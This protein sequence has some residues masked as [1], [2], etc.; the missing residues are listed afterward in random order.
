MVGRACAWCAAGDRKYPDQA[1]L[2]LVRSLFPAVFV[3]A[4][5]FPCVSVAGEPFCT[6]VAPHARRL[7][8]HIPRLMQTPSSRIWRWFLC[9]HFTCSTP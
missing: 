8:P 3:A 5:C 7:R 6:L 9:T 2:S 1:G 4:I